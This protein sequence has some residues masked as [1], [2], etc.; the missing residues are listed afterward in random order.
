MCISR[1]AQTQRNDR[2]PNRHVRG[3]IKVKLMSDQIP[4]PNS[5]RVWFGSKLDDNEET[6][7]I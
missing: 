5:S 1:S 4:V 7:A 3:P 6:F 2:T